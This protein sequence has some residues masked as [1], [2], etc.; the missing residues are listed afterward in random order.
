MEQLKAGK[1]VD[2]EWFDEVSIYFS[3]IV[4]FTNISAASTPIQVYW[5]SCFF[6]L[7]GTK[8]Q[9]SGQISQNIQNWKCIRNTTS[10]AN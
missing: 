1:T 4:G 6:T 7:K 5:I 2:P 3:D 8:R 10:Q 9:H